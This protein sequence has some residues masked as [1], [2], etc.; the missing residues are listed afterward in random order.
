MFVVRSIRDTVVYSYQF[1]SIDSVAFVVVYV[2]TVIVFVA[3][4]VAAV[5]QTSSWV[6]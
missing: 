3:V 6:P 1:V 4:A 5:V 2:I